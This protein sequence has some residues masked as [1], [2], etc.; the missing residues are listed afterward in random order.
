[1]QPKCFDL[2]QVPDVVIISQVACDNLQ[3]QVTE[4]ERERER[5]LHGS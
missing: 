2:E 5:E 3:M 1:M 4:R